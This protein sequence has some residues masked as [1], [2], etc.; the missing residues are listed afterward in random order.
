MIP[1]IRKNKYEEEDFI[2]DEE[3]PPIPVAIPREE[4]L[5]LPRF[6]ST[7]PP[8][9]AAAERMASIENEEIIAPSLEEHEEMEGAA[10]TIAAPKAEIVYKQNKEVKEMAKAAKPS[11]KENKKVKETAKPAETSDM[12]NKKVK[13]TAKPA[14]TSDKEN[15]KVEEAAKPAKIDVS[16][17]LTKT[18]EDFVSSLQDDTDVTIKIES[19][20]RKKLEPMSK[21]IPYSI[22]KP[23][24]RSDNKSI[25]SKIPVLSPRPSPKTTPRPET[26]KS[27]VEKKEKLPASKVGNAVSTKKPVATKSAAESRTV[28]PALPT[29][30]VGKET[31]TLKPVAAKPAPQQ[32]RLSLPPVPTSMVGQ[33]SEWTSSPKLPEFK[34]TKRLPDFNFS[35]LPGKKFTYDAQS[36]ISSRRSKDG[37]LPPIKK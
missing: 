3:R 19:S 1:N 24:V 23:D 28:F 8:V 16:L 12:E 2:T 5:Q 21:P 35:K 6:V 25:W 9:P 36:K 31:K 10:A 22:L 20:R 30:M 29:S 11:D 15:K 32:S 7:S 13:E 26:S 37:F 14:E 18:L 33:Q 4:D 27:A 17:A 34:S